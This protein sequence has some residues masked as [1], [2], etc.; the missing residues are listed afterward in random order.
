ML[1]QLLVMW[2]FKSRNSQ[3][4]FNISIYIYPRSIS[5]GLQSKIC[6]YLNLSRIFW[7]S[8]EVPEVY[9]EV[10]D[11]LRKFQ[12]FFESSGHS[13]E[14]PDFEFFQVFNLHTPSSLSIPQHPKPFPAPR[15]PSPLSPEHLSLKNHC[16]EVPRSSEVWIQVLEGPQIICIPFPKG[17]PQV[18]R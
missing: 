8:L 6:S 15:T 7:K 13:S 9:P 11:F 4:L 14:V 18:S 17:S 12:T 10:P 1:G 2:V 3:S 16:S 5:K